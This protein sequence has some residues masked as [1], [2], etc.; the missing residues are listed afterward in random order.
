M[1]NV[2]A[3][4]QPR[5]YGYPPIYHPGH[6]LGRDGDHVMG[7]YRDTMEYPGVVPASPLGA[8]VPYHGMGYPLLA[9]GCSPWYPIW[10]IW[11][12]LHDPFRTTIRGTIH[13]ECVRMYIMRYTI[14]TL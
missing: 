4:E 11:G 2:L 14:H 7:P 8:G 12:A 6:P 3:N 10:T 1:R 13:V 5:D 9:R